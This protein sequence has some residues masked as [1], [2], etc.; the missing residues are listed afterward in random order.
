MTLFHLSSSQGVGNISLFI[1]ALYLG[2][3]YEKQC[4]L[5][6]SIALHMTF[7]SISVIRILFYN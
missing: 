2:F 7:N 1:F 6:A 5:F 3:L 4:S